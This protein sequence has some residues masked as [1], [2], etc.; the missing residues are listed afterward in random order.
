MPAQYVISSNTVPAAGSVE[1]APPQ[2]IISPNTVPAAASVEVAP[3]EGVT[4]TV[5]PTQQ[6]YIQQPAPV[7]YVQAPEQA[8][9]APGFTM[10]QS[11]TYIDYENA[12]F[13]EPAPVVVDA[14]TTATT[15]TTTKAKSS[16]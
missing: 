5:A 2:Y 13:V 16:K 8:V 10:G 14:A 4:Y 11:Y 15:A 9:A 3:A 12:S 1:V 6:Y 7:T